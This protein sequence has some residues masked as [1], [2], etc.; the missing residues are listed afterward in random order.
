MYKKETKT[1]QKGAGGRSN[2]EEAEITR[3]NKIKNKP[4]KSIITILREI[5]YYHNTTTGSYL[6]SNYYF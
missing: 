5:I 3:E 4:P 2:L 6:E 1:D